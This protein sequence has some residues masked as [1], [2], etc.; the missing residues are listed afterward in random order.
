M[1]VTKQ[2]SQSGQDWP[3]QSLG[4]GVEFVPERGGFR[5]LVNFGAVAGLGVFLPR[6]DGVELGD[7]L[8]AIEQRSGAQGVELV[9]TEVVASALHVADLQ[10]AED[11]FE[12]WDI[13]EEELFLQIFRAGGD[14]D[15]LLALA[16]EAEG[17]QEVGEGFAGASAGFDDEVALVGEGG[18]Y[19]AGHLELA[20]TVLKGEGGLREETAGGEEFLERGK[21]RLIFRRRVEIGGWDGNDLDGGR[22]SAVSI[23]FG[24]S[25][26]LRFTPNPSGTRMKRW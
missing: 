13:L 21:A 22:H 20:G 5:Q 19:G 14:D 17:R 16:G 10:R 3:R 6:G 15:A 9:A 7:L 26:F 11:A 25:Y 8:E 4:A 24:F 1:V 23:L 2:R 18:L 12:E